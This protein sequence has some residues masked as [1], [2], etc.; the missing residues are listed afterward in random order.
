[1]TTFPS[2]VDGRVTISAGDITREALDAVV[3]AADGSLLGGGDGTIHRAGGPEVFF[4]A[5]DAKTF[6]RHQRFTR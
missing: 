1:M 3:N 6:L 5:S 4:Q 2:F